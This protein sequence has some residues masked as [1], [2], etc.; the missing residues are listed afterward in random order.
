MDFGTNPAG[1]PAS[2]KRS[3]QAENFGI[4]TIE[5]PNGQRLDGYI[6]LSAKNAAKLG[7]NADQLKTLVAQQKKGSTG[8]TLHLQFGERDLTVADAVEINFG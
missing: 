4:V 2:G 1:A 5:L 3:K 6:L 8:A 7:I